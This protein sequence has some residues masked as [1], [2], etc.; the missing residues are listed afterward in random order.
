M[1]RLHNLLLTATALLAASVLTLNGQS[2]RQDEFPTSRRQHFGVYNLSDADAPKVETKVP[3][4]YKAVGISHYGRH[5]SRYYAGE[6]GSFLE[7]YLLLEKAA[8]DSAL[9]PRGLQ[10]W[11]A[12]RSLY[13]ALKGRE[14]E[15]SQLGRAQHRGI[16][17]RMYSQYKN[18]FGSNAVKTAWSTTVPR[19]IESMGAFCEELARCDRR[20]EVVQ[21]ASVRYVSQVSSMQDFYYFYKKYDSRKARE[22]ER[23]YAKA[24]L[25]TL[26]FGRQIFRDSSYQV[27]KLLTLEQGLWTAYLSLPSSDCWGSPEC[28]ALCEA[29]E[30][31]DGSAPLYEDTMWEQLSRIARRI[32]LIETC[33]P[34]LHHS[35]INIFLVD[36]MLSLA[37][38]DLQSGK[39][40]VR[41]R[42]GHDTIL[43][44]ILKDMGIRGWR[45]LG[46]S[47]AN[48]KE[49]CTS[50]IPM[51][52]NLQM[53]F[54]RKKG[55]PVLFKLM[56]NESE[57][58]LPIPAVTG[59]LYD[60]EAFK[61]YMAPRIEKGKAEALPYLDGNPYPIPY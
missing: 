18:L 38:S 11:E 21:D 56:L 30:G 35:T 17:R 49:W 31:K 37:D 28:Q 60:W 14:S 22:M 32:H 12:Y 2:V 29:I 40:F 42:F 26:A 39:P 51:A 9:N 47:E 52:S 58:E 59:R 54:Y 61:A 43:E 13:P 20:I 16:A 33:E 36:A 44:T 19:C 3:A 6:R 7:V 55:A 48:L 57:L 27:G 53:V 34:L 15:L 10:V 50:R 1:T 23:A 45:N 25:D 4:G 8:A 5:G 41:L 46:D 24:N